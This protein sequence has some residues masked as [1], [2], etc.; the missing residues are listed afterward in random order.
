MTINN[1]ADYI[2][3]KTCRATMDELTTRDIATH[4]N[5]PVKDAYSIACKAATLDLITKL[6]PVNG[7]S[8]EYCGWIAN[9]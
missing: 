4:F 8:F 5:I 3:S 2:N 7:R 6:E 1:T 9:T